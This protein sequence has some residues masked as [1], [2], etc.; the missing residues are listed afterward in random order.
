MPVSSYDS[1]GGRRS[2]GRAALL[3]FLNAP[4]VTAR[5][6][7]RV[8]RCSAATISAIRSGERA[9]ALRVAVEL[10]R[11][12]GIRPAAW[13]APESDCESVDVQQS[14]SESGHTQDVSGASAA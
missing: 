7:A 6:L 14:E 3:R 2:A 11:H 12:V 9:P 4:G 13:L 8:C 5:A 1:A 10:E